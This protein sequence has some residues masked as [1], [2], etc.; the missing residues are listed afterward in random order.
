MTATA[1]NETLISG[2]STERKIRSAI[3]L[4]LTLVAAV[5]FLYDGTIGYPQENVR[6]ALVK[7][8]GQA[9]GSVLP[10]PNEEL[11]ASV[12][13]SAIDRIAGEGVTLSN[14]T[15][16]W[17]S[18]A[19]RGEDR[20][21]FLGVGGYVLA[22]ISGDPPAVVTAEWNDGPKHSAAE[23]MSQKLIGAVLAIVA[24]ALLLNLCRVLATR[25]TLTDDELRIPRYRPIPLRA[26][27]DIRPREPAEQPER[28]IE[29]VVQRG[30][31]TQTVLLERYFVRDLSRFAERLRA[32]VRDRVEGEKSGEE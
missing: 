25:A 4:T 26:I 32:Y 19:V 8:M 27:Q 28:A 31:K 12:A 5:Y 6:E 22:E 21:L 11:T 29:L 18:P 10:T 16:Q 1:Q 20:A 13:D 15:T 3:V 14:L 17:G 24:I 30:S 7:V 2:T 23:L 9:P